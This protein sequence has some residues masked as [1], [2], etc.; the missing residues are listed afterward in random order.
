MKLVSSAMACLHR[1]VGISER[2]MLFLF[3][4]ILISRCFIDVLFEITCGLHDQSIDVLRR[5]DN[6]CDKQRKTNKHRLTSL[7]LVQLERRD[8]YV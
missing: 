7:V 5:S 8:V 3:F 6:Y 1:F 4:F 2:L